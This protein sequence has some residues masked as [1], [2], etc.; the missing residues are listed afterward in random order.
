MTDKP[1]LEQQD[2]DKGPKRSAGKLASCVSKGEEDSNTLLLPNKAGSE[3][4][5]PVI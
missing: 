3:A 4:E 2:L 1:V 5:K